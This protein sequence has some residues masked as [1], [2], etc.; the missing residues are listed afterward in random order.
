[1]KPNFFIVGAPKCGTTAL[2]EYLREHP[3]IFITKPKEPHYFASDF[4]NYPYAKSLAAYLEL[5]EEVEQ[6]HLAI[7]EASVLY[8]YSSDAIK[9][10]Y[11]F[12]P[13]AKII[14]MLRKPFDMVYSYH[15]QLLY[16]GFESELDFTKAWELQ[17]LR[18]QGK[19]IPHTCTEPKIL[20]YSEVGKLGKQMARLMKIF[21]AEQIYP[22]LFEDFIVDTKT[23]YEKALDFL[24]V[25]QDFRT[26]F[27]PINENKVHKLRFVGQFTQQT[28][29]LLSNVAMKTKQLLGIERLYVLDTLR[30]MNNQKVKRQPLT[31]D[32]R[33]QL[34]DEFRDDIQHLSLLLNQNLNHWL[35]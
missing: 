28:P 34:V 9:N 31:E 27:P 25:P 11:K 7:G 2:S 35:K 8:L 21:P 32:F 3:Q 30:Q 10:I 22:I 18:S 1:M 15:S 17:S 6:Q 13:Q 24:E 16:S 19:S 23:I 33:L 29:S 4:P 20:Q 14:V 5:F 12:N 26:D